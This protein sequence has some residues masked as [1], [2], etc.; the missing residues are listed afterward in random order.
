MAKANQMKKG[1]AQ[2]NPSQALEQ[3]CVR[4]FEAEVQI[5]HHATTIK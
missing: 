4:E 2:V 5:L 3:L 1:G